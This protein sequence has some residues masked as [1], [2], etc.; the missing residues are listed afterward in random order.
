MPN[1]SYYYYLITLKLAL[2]AAHM[3]NIVI[4]AISYFFLVN[5]QRVFSLVVHIYGIHCAVLSLQIAVIHSQR[6][7][8]VLFSTLYFNSIRTSL[9]YIQSFIFLHFSVML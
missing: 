7:E 2:P 5:I 4:V 6:R 3:H 8:V 9:F 1:F